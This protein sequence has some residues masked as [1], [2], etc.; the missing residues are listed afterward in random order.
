MG[1]PRGIFV[2]RGLESWLP[3]CKQD[4]VI[5]VVAEHLPLVAWYAT[6]FTILVRPAHLSKMDGKNT[7]FRKV[8]MCR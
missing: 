1:F 3:Q 5:E 8:R 2:F 6:T 4:D 7:K